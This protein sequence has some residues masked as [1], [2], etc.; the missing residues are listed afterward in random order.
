M[1]KQHKTLFIITIS[2]ILLIGFRYYH[3][4]KYKGIIVVFFNTKEGD[5]ILIRNTDFCSI[6]IDGGSD[7]AMLDS[8]YK[9]LPFNKRD[10]DH[11][12]VSHPH[13]D[14][15][16]GLNLISKRFEIQNLYYPF[17]PFQKES[18]D[19]L[20]DLS[21]NKFEVNQEIKDIKACELDFKV[22][23]VPL[24]KDEKDLNLHSLV[25]E[26][27]DNQEFIFFAAGDIYQEQENYLMQNRNLKNVYLFKSNHHGSK[28]SNSKEFLEFLNPKVTVV[29]A[30]YANRFKH[31]HQ[32]AIQN[33]AQHS[34]LVLRTDVEG[35]ILIQPP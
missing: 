31:P 2:L 19:D 11:V 8:L 25:I 5:A 29:T 1:K 32:K 34:R 4:T 35:E 21:K 33:I 17:L 22:Y 13:H 26:I 6:L 23:K 18:L 27:Y 30:G 20:K 7:Y 16:H 15:I 14:H 3:L 9:Y 10:F 24:E 12:F 28:T